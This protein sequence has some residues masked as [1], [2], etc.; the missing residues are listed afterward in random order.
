[1]SKSEKRKNIYR[2][3]RIFMF[4]PLIIQTSVLINSFKHLYTKAQNVLVTKYAENILITT[5][6]ASVRAKPFTIVA[7]N[8]D[9][10][11]KRITLVIKAA[12]FESRI[13]GQARL[14][15]SSTACARFLPLLIL[16]LDA[17]IAGYLHQARYQHSTRAGNA[18]EG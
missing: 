6:N 7:P 8:A 3:P 2:L 18:W 11:Q 1:M 10:N 17:Q 14:Q 16:P 4:L 12:R 13:E 5:P 9:P 15:L